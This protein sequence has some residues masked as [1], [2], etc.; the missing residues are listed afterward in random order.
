[1]ISFMVKNSIKE[2]VGDNTTE[3]IVNYGFVR[4]PEAVNGSLYFDNLV[5][6]H[7]N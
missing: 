1:M 5:Q 4:L 3:D 7:P 2:Y 6:I